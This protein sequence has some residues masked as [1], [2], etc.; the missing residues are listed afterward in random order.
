MQL[1]PR[2][3]PRMLAALSAWLTQ[4]VEVLLMGKPGAEMDQFLKSAYQSN[5]PGQV[6]I[7]IQDRWRAPKEF[8]WVYE[9]VKSQTK[10][11]GPVTAYVCEGYACRLPTADPE[12]FRRLLSLPVR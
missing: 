1:S 12:E 2:S 8:P 5:F 7:A 3:Q 11:L 6:I 4:P 10:E 9:M